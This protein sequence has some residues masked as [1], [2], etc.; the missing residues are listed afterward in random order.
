MLFC[1]ILCA[2]RVRR[3]ESRHAPSSQIPLQHLHIEMLVQQSTPIRQGAQNAR[4]AAKILKTIK[5]ITGSCS[6]ACVQICCVNVRLEIL[7][8]VTSEHLFIY[9]PCQEKKCRPAATFAL[10]SGK[11][12]VLHYGDCFVRISAVY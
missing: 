2:A 3:L 11:S 9:I 7:I 4:L 5:E 12:L 10:V 1:N 6:P 8:I